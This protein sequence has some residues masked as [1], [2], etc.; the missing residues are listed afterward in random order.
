MNLTRMISVFLLLA[1]LA[2]LACSAEPKKAASLTPAAKFQ[3][4]VFQGITEETLRSGGAAFTAQLTAKDLTFVRDVSLIREV[5]E[6]SGFR[7]SSAESSAASS[8]SKSLRGMVAGARIVVSSDGRLLKVTLGPASDFTAI[9]AVES[10]TLV[11]PAQILE[12]STPTEKRDIIGPQFK[13]V[14]VVPVQF[15]LKGAAMPIVGDV[16][17]LQFTGPHDVIE[18]VV[19]SVSIVEGSNCQ[20]SHNAQVA[21][22]LWNASLQTL[23]FEPLQGGLLTVCATPFAS[24]PEL[25]VRIKGDSDLVVAGPEGV[26]TEPALLRAQQ[27]FSG[28]IFGTGLTDQDQLV[29]V[30]GSTCENVDGLGDFYDLTYSSPSRTVFWGNLPTQ[31][32]Y[33]VCY[34]R[35]GSQRF[36]KVNTLAVDRGGEVIVDRNLPQLLVEADTTVARRV[37]IDYLTV[38]SGTLSIGNFPVNVTHFVWT[39]GNIVGSAT[40]SSRGSN[41]KISFPSDTRTVESVISNYGSMII[42]MRHLYFVQRGALLNYGSLEILVNSSSATDPSTVFAE[43]PHSSIIN[44]PTGKITFRFIG[45]GG[46]LRINVPFENRGTVLIPPEGLVT[47]HNAQ[48]QTTSVLHM[49]HGSELHVS[50][51]RLTG[52]IVMEADCECELLVA[53]ESE[54][55]MRTLRVL[56]DGSVSILGGRVALES[57]HFE[58]PLEV[59][60]DSHSDRALDVALFGSTVFHGATVTAVQNTVFSSSQLSYLIFDGQLVCQIHST[61]FG[62]NIVVQNNLAGVLFA[63]GI[64]DVRLSP[65]LIPQNTS[66]VVPKN[67]TLVLMDIGNLTQKSLAEHATAPRLCSYYLVV[68]MYIDVGGTILLWGCAMLPYGGVINGIIH[69]SNAQEIEA[70]VSYAFCA[71]VLGNPAH[72]AC[73]PFFPEHVIP[74]GIQLSGQFEVMRAALPS[75]PT[76]NID[77][78][79]LRSAKLNARDPVEFLSYSSFHVDTHSTM[80]LTHG[81]LIASTSLTLEGTAEIS[82]LQPLYVRGP[83]EIGST[84]II[85]TD[86]DVKSC[87][88]A[89]LSSE[90]VHFAVGSQIVAARRYNLSSSSASIVNSALRISGRPAVDVNSFLNNKNTVSGEIV[91]QTNTV[92]ISFL[93]NSEIPNRAQKVVLTLS[94]LALCMILLLALSHRIPFAKFRGELRL[95]PQTAWQLSWPEF[96]S[97]S[98][99]FFAASAIIFEAMMLSAPSFHYKLPL[100]PTVRVLTDYSMNFMLPHMLLSSS[101]FSILAAAFTF[102][103]VLAWLPTAPRLSARVE[104]DPE[105]ATVSRSQ[106]GNTDLFNLA[107]LV[108]QFQVFARRACSFLFIPI[109]SVLLEGVTCNMFLE[110]SPGC[111]AFTNHFWMSLVAVF[112]F[113]FLVPFSG[114]CPTAPYAHPPYERELDLRVKRTFSYVHYT[115][116]TFQVFAWK[117]FARDPMNL[118][119]VS[120][121]VQLTLMGMHFAWSPCAYAAVNRFAAFT[122]LYPV[123]SSA[124]GLIQIVR[125]GVGSTFVC[126]SPDPLYIALLSFLWLCVVILQVLD[127]RHLMH[128]ENPF[129]PDEQLHA[130]YDELQAMYADMS[131]ARQKMHLAASI[132]EREDC[133]RELAKARLNTLQ[134]L[135]RYRLKKEETLPLFYLGSHALISLAPAEEDGDSHSGRAMISADGLLQEMKSKFSEVANQPDGL[136]STAAAFD[137]PLD[138]D[139]MERFHLG[140]QI[141]RGSYGTVHM[142]MLPTGKLVAV[143]LIPIV[144]KKKETLSAVRMEVD[145]LQTLVHKHVIRYYGFHFHGARIHLFMEFAVGGSLTSLVRKF[146]GLTEPLIG[147]YT[148][149]ILEGLNYLHS[150]HVVHRDIKG[151]NILIDGSGVVKLADFGCSKSLSDIANRSQNGCGTLV[152]SPYWMAPEVIKSEAYGTKADIWSVGCTVVEMLNGGDPPW[153]QK[154]DNVYSAMF[155]IGSTA[156]IPSNIPDDTSGLCRDFLAKC[157]ERDVSKRAS[158]AELLKHPWLVD[159]AGGNSPN[160]PQ[161]CVAHRPQRQWSDLFE[162]TPSQV[163]SYQS[164]GQPLLSG[165]RREKSFRSEDSSSNAA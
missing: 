8:W 130:M 24:N 118:L 93:E 54:V 6:V 58:G 163:G 53:S 123:T 152:G 134:L 145:M 127:V 2:P 20:F 95:H 141:G 139:E 35:S 142:A 85:R 16:V 34:Q 73:V 121:M 100:P 83:V 148:I 72:G 126:A 98:A 63:S 12:S 90:E 91:A 67:A 69:G 116:L 39:G 86:L 102:L 96:A 104:E 41:S 165:D 60:L 26:S 81:G 64:S 107:A 29:I 128:A 71:N 105:V 70:A 151:E 146:R 164:D 112:A 76:V 137:R 5:L 94:A 21:N 11:L 106:A 79:E 38:M 109:L 113:A 159:A 47:L 143:K 50:S 15:F 110:G 147:Y 9:T 154:F 62:S 56:G 40:I 31:G 82:S 33:A 111:D 138:A 1:L 160:D 153:H 36:V 97:F 68:P 45:E 25:L 49:F 74:S 131:V 17:S 43:S 78:F 3:G 61:S 14:P 4:S 66:F 87:A 89:L 80:V 75:P 59:S 133:G 65:Q 77:S 32:M 10:I 27:D 135:R 122:L 46:S 18:R 84:G 92:G 129:H 37:H 119:V 22:P 155:Y 99:N 144:K 52:S 161:T 120:M 48:L 125:F 42:E 140:P 55:T 150:Q 51:G 117:I 101:F 57:S 19:H 149:Q 13:T 157:F 108:G 124:C 156:D 44:F 30:P 162:D 88:P 7:M 103:W 136:S 114:C 115:L 28:I 23:F 158:A 132:Q